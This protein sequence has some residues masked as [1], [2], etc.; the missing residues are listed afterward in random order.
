MHSAE[1]MGT[2]PS[3]GASRPGTGV[4]AELGLRGAGLGRSGRSRVPEPHPGWA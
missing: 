2:W 4:G 1:L 3:F